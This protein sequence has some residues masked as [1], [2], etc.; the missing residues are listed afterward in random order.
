MRTTSVQS[1]RRDAIHVVLFQKTTYKLSVLGTHFLPT[2]VASISTMRLYGIS[3]KSSVVLLLFFATASA[4]APT[5][6]F[7]SSRSVSTPWLSTRLH[8][9]ASIDELEAQYIQL[10]DAQHS[11]PEMVFILVY[12]PYTDEEGVHTTEY[13]KGSG[14]Q[15]MLVFESI[16][17]CRYLSSVLAVEPTVPGTP[18]PTPA[19][20]A[21]MEQA[22][23][24]MGWAIK[25][26]PEVTS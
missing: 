18:V 23:Q 6:F 10:A 17:D 3:I 11:A 5:L 24:Q 19:P 21:Q 22:C 15:A 25:V 16:D 26:I 9:Q 12:K 7:T 13:P 14:Q 8:Q 2:V 20:L 4:F 1:F